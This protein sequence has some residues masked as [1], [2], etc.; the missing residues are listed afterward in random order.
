[1]RDV[2]WSVAALLFVVGLAAFC[3]FLDWGVY[4]AHHVRWVP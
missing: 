2:S 1:M 4:L 3:E